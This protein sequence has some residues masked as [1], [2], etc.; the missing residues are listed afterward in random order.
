MGTDAFFK[1]SI[2]NNSISDRN[3]N[4]TILDTLPYVGD[5]KIVPEEDGS[6]LPRESVFAVNI[7]QSLESI[8]E[9]AEVLKKWSVFYTTD[10]QADSLESVRDANYVTADQIRDFRQVKSIKLV[11]N[12]T[13]AAGETNEFILKTRLPKNAN[14]AHNSKVVNSTA[15]SYNNTE[16]AEG[17]FAGIAVAKY[18]VSGKIFTDNDKNGNN[19]DADAPLAGYVVTLVGVDG[20]PVLNDRKQPITTTSKADGSYEFVVFDRGEYSVKITK[21]SPTEEITRK[22][23]ELGTTGNDAEQDGTTPKFSLT[24]E[25][26]EATRNFGFIVTRGSITL[27]KKNPD[28]E[29]LSGVTFRLEKNGQKIG[30]SQITNNEGKIIWSNLEL[31]EY[32]LIEESTLPAYRLDTTPTAVTINTANPNITKEIINQK[33]NW[34][35]KIIKKNPQ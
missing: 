28:N 12:G 29:I 1:I 21:K 17:N 5:H 9:N 11:L 34:K 22:H 14:L 27:V 18:K 4:L 32:S 16:F 2:F 35:V 3:G 15:F 7:S 26:P 25:N 10:A 30:D 33:Q 20:N 13:L 24:P 8:P 6:F 31:G 19:T 23:T